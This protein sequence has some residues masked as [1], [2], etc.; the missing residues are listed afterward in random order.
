MCAKV[1]EGMYLMVRKEDGKTVYA[2]MYVH[3]FKVVQSRKALEAGR[4]LAENPEFE[5]IKSTADK[6]KWCRHS[7]G[8]MQ[9]EVAEYAGI[10]R[11]TYAS[12][13]EIGRDYYPIEIIQK[14]AG[15][16]GVDVADL[17]DEYNSFL[18]RGQGKQIREHRKMRK[19]TQTEFAK[20][21]DV[22]VGTLKEWERDRIFM[23]KK[24]WE[25]L[26]KKW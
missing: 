5:K 20:M 22:P 13:E 19:M 24:S 23:S 10:Y 18:Y 11:S 14:I 6:L 8:L 26:V 1:G 3:G 21:L 12:Y 17:L 2:P 9:K 16:F 25:R 4:F 7:L 15:L